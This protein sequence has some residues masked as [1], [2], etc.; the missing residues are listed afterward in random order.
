MTSISFIEKVPETTNT[1]SLEASLA[2]MGGWK[3]LGW[4]PGNQYP[5]YN[6]QQTDPSV[7]GC[8]GDTHSVLAGS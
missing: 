8:I 5:A 6:H 1:T 3:P 4:Q 7:A 2:E